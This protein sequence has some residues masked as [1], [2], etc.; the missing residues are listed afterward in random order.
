M[1]V[2]VVMPV[3]A[4]LMKINKCKAFGA[5]V[6]VQGEN[7]TDAKKIALGMAREKGMSYLNGYDHPHA[8]AGQGIIALEIIDQIGIPDVI[9]APCGG[10]GLIA[11]VCA[12]MSEKAPDCKI[13][14]VESENC[15]GFATAMKVGRAKRI[16]CKVSIADGL[17]VAKI[18]YNVFAT[19]KGK[20]A[21]VVTVSET[22][23]NVAITHLLELE[24]VITE[25]AGACPLAALLSGELSHLKGKKIVLICS[26]GNIDTPILMRVV[27]KGLAT[28]GRYIKYSVWIS[29]RVGGQSELLKLVNDFGVNVKHINFERAWVSNDNY[30]VRVDMQCETR[31]IENAIELR[32]ALIAKYEK[33][34]FSDFPNPC[35]AR[36]LSKLDM[37]WS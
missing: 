6:V 3:V 37:S 4:P 25:G 22:L 19:C 36:A 20:V 29:D 10:G 28:L 5:N 31:D 21:Q 15:P 18:G 2:T 33:V 1:P 11:G 32:N 23:I 17:A 14:G 30:M 34:D 8:I 24:K 12:V 13:I 7:M 27:E 26:G 9:I 16:N 35:Q